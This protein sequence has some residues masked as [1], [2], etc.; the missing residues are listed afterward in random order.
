MRCGRR[1]LFGAV[2]IALVALSLPAGASLIDNRAGADA[3]TIYFGQPDTVLYAQGIT[4]DDVFLADVGLRLANEQAGSSNTE[5]SLLV[6]GARA[7][8]GGGLG[9]A[10]D[11]SNVLF[12]SGLNTLTNASFMD[13]DW[14]VNVAV[15][16]GAMYFIVIDSRPY[17][18][19]NDDGVAASYSSDVYAGGEFV[20]WNSWMGGDPNAGAW[21][22]W[23]YP[24][25]AF[26]ANFTSDTPV[27]P[28]PEPATLTLLGVSLGGLALRQWRRR[29]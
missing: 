12:D 11:L 21:T 10:P 17:P 18:T 28:V 3:A 22:R 26:M 15:T 14:N 27:P 6:T 8:G 19:S 9:M 7:D 16:S 1:S 23:Q 13:F 5:F 2:A 29:A 25:M 4:A 24:D 20:Y